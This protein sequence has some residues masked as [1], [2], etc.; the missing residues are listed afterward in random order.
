MKRTFFFFLLIT[1][2]SSEKPHCWICYFKERYVN[3]NNVVVN[4]YRQDLKIP[5]EAGMTQKDIYLL[6]D[7]NT[8]II[9]EERSIGLFLE[10]EIVKDKPFE[11]V[12]EDSV[13]YSTYEKLK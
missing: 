13:I 7:E 9:D 8:F 3:E 1:A 5:L 12:K 6:E 10:C 4:S 2:C 11:F